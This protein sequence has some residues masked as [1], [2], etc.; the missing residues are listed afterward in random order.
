[1]K[2]PPRGRLKVEDGFRREAREGCRVQSCEDLVEGGDI[3]ES[4]VSAA[5]RK[6]RHARPTTAGCMPPSAASFSRSRFSSRGLRRTSEPDRDTKACERCSISVDCATRAEVAL[7]RDDGPDFP[8]E[9]QTRVR[10]RALNPKVF[11]RSVRAA[12]T[13]LVRCRPVASARGPLP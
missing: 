13:Q 3:G 1:M 9:G 7:W 4:E 6:P 10:A 12:P 2:R 8:C 5:L 11:G